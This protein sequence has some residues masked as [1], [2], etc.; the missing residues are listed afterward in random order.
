MEED[1]QT[2]I[3]KIIAT[4]DNEKKS[5]SIDVDDS[6]TF[7]EFKKILSSA[8]HLLKNNF[9]I[10]HKGQEYANEYDDNSIKEL[11]PELK[12]INLSIKTKNDINEIEDE[13]VS[14]KFNIKIPCEKHIEKYKVLYC[15]TCNKSICT[16]CSNLT[17]EHINHIIE[18]KSH[19]IAPAKLLINNVFSN[20]NIFKANSKL[21]KY[22]DSI[23]FR[24]ELNIKIFDNLKKLIKNI[25]DKFNSCLEFF[26][27]N[28]D[29]TEKNTNYNIE[30]LKNYYIEYFIKLKNDIEMKNILLD[31]E[32]F[33]T[34]YQKLKEIEKYKNEYLKLNMEKYEKLNALLNPFIEQI[35]K[36]SNNIKNN[37][38]Q[39]LNKDIYDIFINNIEENIVKLI[40]KEKISDLMFNNISVQRKSLIRTSTGVFNQNNNK[41]KNIINL[42]EKK[43]IEFNN[44]NEKIL[45]QK[46]DAN[47]ISK[48]KNIKIN[49]GYEIS[50][51]SGINNDINNNLNNEKQNK[52][53]QI[54]LKDINIQNFEGKEDLKIK[55]HN[56][57]IIKEEKV[58][59]QDNNKY[60][61]TSI[62]NIQT[63]IINKNIKN[64]ISNNSKKII[65]PEMNILPLKKISLSSLIKND[66]SNKINCLAKNDASLF[67]KDSSQKNINQTY[68]NFAMN[69]NIKK[70]NNINYM[71]SNL[72]LYYHEGE[73]SEENINDINKPNHQNKN[74]EK[75]Q[76]SIN[77][78][79]NNLISI[80]N[81]ELNKREEEPIKNNINKN[82]LK[83]DI[84]INKDNSEKNI[85]KIKKEEKNEFNNNILFKNIDQ[86]HVNIDSKPL[87]LCIYPIFNTNY[88]LGAFKDEKTEKF[89]VDFEQAFNKQDIQLKEFAQGGAY[90]NSG[91]YLFISGGQEKQIGIGQ[92]FL[93]ITINENDKK[94]KMVKMPMMNFSHWNHSMISYENYI[95]SL[96][97]YFSNKCELFNLKTLRWEKIAS[98]NYEE[99]QR[100]ILAIHNNYLYAFM[101]YNRFEIL[102]T[103]E[104]INISN[105]FINKWENINISNEYDL[106]LKFYGSGV[107]YHG[108]KLYFIGG[109]VGHGEE[110]NDYKTE[111]Y[112]FN[113]ESM[114]F[115]DCE[116]AFSGKLNFIE[117][118]FHYF[119]EDNFGNFT[120]VNNGCLATINVSSLS[121]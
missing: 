87:F 3:R 34:V 39:I 49:L 94:V 8:A 41:R 74:E 60:I 58:V 56:Q 53:E 52:T 36:F 35:N 88:I 45:F 116:I 48:N 19:Y 13:L 51:I 77:L 70:N 7:Y 25:E 21:S 5:Y 93:R 76:I 11:F 30:L 38:E 55:E 107:C 104:R 100:A 117:N 113:F 50:E 89:K 4:I 33:L 64:N 44:K 54:C 121:Q 80:L 98:F 2:N 26:S 14:V 68:N 16:D 115:N 73:T 31:D 101:G 10:Y 71:N 42:Y 110:E 106:N 111:I 75:N 43:E 17:E 92:I 82:K 96:G 105:I 22:S 59:L 29:L 37:F 62:N 95:F 118:K 120:C 114:G 6:T 47:S 28:E 1:I 63:N 12:T 20:A 109:K 86:T 97:G 84:K 112:C 18:E 15:F 61:I 66:I 9:Q 27:I 90:S 32:I 69:N 78:S 65:D 67:K 81:K 108:N 103:V 24:A 91:K 40:E 102:D 119:D 85:N 79:N 83:I 57:D 23:N 99:R 46:N 72:I